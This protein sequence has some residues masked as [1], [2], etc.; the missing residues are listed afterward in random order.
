MLINKKS[1][2]QKGLVSIVVTLIVIL[3][4]SL[5]VIGFSRLT[6]RSQ[7]QT[8]D[9][10]LNTQSLYAAETGVNDAVEVLKQ[11]LAA[12][13]SGFLNANYTDCDD[14]M[15]AANLNDPINPK[16]VLDSSGQ[17]VSYTCLIVDPTPSTLTYQ[18]VASLDY[19]VVPVKSKDGSSIRTIQVSW[20]NP[21]NAADPEPCTN[22]PSDLPKADGW[23][24]KNPLMRIDLISESSTKSITSLREEEFNATFFAYPDID[25]SGSTSFPAVSS[26]NR[27]RMVPARCDDS[28]SH[29]CTI[30]IDPRRLLPFC[31]ATCYAESDFYYLRL[32]PIYGIANIDVSATDAVGGGGTKQELTG[33]QAVID[34]TGKAQDVLKRIQVHASLF[35]SNRAPFFALQTATNLC[36]LLEVDSS[37]GNTIDATNCPTN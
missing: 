23:T 27:G 28:G 10:Q 36:K 19:R 30:S 1:S 37:G 21:A 5:I 13:D 24:C 4:I 34:A 32:A 14:F 29:R 6:R 8:L 31:G 15:T 2:D 11:K 20:E 25:G 7:Q 12:G 35:N 9:K 26:T 17:G 22:L 33:A 16:N 3:V 18:N